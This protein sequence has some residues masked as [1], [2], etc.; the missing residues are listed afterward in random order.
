MPA[1]EAVRTQFLILGAG[2]FAAGALITPVA[3][4]VRADGAGG[5]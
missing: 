1:R 5:R 4:Q 2:L 3:A